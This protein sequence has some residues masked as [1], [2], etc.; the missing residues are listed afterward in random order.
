M[1]K[2]K[3]HGVSVGKGWERHNRTHFDEIVVNYDK[4]RWSYPGELIQD[5]ITY[6]GTDG[7]NALEIGAGTGKATAPLLDAGYNITAVEIGGNMAAFLQDKF[8]DRNF[9]VNIAAFEDFVLEDSCYDIVYAA[10]AFHWVDAEIG[11]AK[12]YR[13]LKNGGTFALF[14]SNIDPSNGEEPYETMQELYKKHFWKPYQRPAKQTN[15]NMWSKAGILRG[16]GFDDM[17]SYGFTDITM[18]SYDVTLSYTPDEYVALQDTMSDH[19]NLP[20]NDRA[21]LYT[22]MKDAIQRHGGIYNVNYV[23][24]LYMGRKI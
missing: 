6:Q 23:F 18:S 4:S 15:E 8:K 5:I 3:Q 11:C 24:Q 13:C 14:R 12:A 2:F 16:Y 10:S 7:K 19:R 20:D 1:D 9:N 22:G 17:T 21:A